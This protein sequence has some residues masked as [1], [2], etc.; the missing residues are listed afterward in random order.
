MIDR[1]TQYPGHLAKL[2]AMRLQ[3]EPGNVPTA[4]FV[5]DP[6]GRRPADLQCEAA[7]P[8]T[9]LEKICL[10]VQHLEWQLLFDYCHRQA[11]K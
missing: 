2:V 7:R 1:T 3:S 11:V 9:E 6:N 8:G 5:F 4:T 10:E